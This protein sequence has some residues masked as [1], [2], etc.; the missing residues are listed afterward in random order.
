VRGRRQAADPDL[1]D[2]RAGRGTHIIGKLLGAGEPRPYLGSDALAQLCQHHPPSGALEQ[3]PSALLLQLADPAADVRLAR[4][5]S[6]GHLAQ[7]AELG[8]IHEKLPSCVIHEI[9]SGYT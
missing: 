7:A 6:Q 9:I 1:A 3:A 8:S 4:A 2:R 5:I